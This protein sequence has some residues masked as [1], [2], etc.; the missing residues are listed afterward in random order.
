MDRLTLV[1][2]LAALTPLSAGAIAPPLDRRDPT[3]YTGPTTSGPTQTTDPL[4]TIVAT[5]FT[6]QAYPNTELW[7]NSTTPKSE[8][9][10]LNI[11]S[12]TGQKNDTAPL[13]YGW[14]FEDIDV[15]SPKNPFTQRIRTHNPQ[16]SGDGGIYAELIQNRAFQGSGAVLGNLPG[17][18]G[19]SVLESEN[20]TIPFGP[21][22]GA[23]RAIGDVR[24]SL[25][26]IH[27][28]SDALRTVMQVD[29]RE[30]ATGEAGFLNEGWYGM[31]VSPQ[32]YN[33]SFYILADMR[34]VNQ[35]QPKSIDVSLRSNLTGEVWTTVSIPVTQNIS[36]FSYTQFSTIINNNV[37][38]P[39]ANNSFA[40]TFDAA[41][42][43][44][45]TFYFDL[46]SLFPETYKNRTNGLRKDLAQ[47]FKDLNPK[48]L[49]FPGGN[50]IEGLSPSTRWKWFET[51]G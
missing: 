47:N 10:A 12:R 8:S 3:G 50:N 29:I 21:T 46:I 11:L 31:D 17:I 38:A 24:L 1:A 28:L 14:M 27:P 33:A 5:P 37:T 49:R 45:T 51:I 44:G 48:F 40:I 41:Q 16:H 23:Y 43:Q 18:P 9:V 20:P 15:R 34:N 6:V 32:Q 30:N 42:M 4:S 7:Q 19:T 22:L 25:D 39:N 35:P 2:A 36:T 13:L 26:I